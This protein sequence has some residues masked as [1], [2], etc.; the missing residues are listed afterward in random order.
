MCSQLMVCSAFMF[1]RGEYTQSR[2]D[3][4][5]LFSVW[6]ERKVRSVHASAARLSWTPG[7]G[8]EKG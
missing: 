6:S 4:F 8:V 5:P 3:P 7:A 2:A 1:C